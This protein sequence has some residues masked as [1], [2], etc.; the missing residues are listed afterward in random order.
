MKSDFLLAGLVVLRNRSDTEKIQEV[1][2]T[3]DICPYTSYNFDEH[4]YEE[5]KQIVLTFSKN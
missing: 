1:R 3:L 2:L 4:R 5:G